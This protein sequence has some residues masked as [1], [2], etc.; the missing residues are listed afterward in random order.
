MAIPHSK[1]VVAPVVPPTASSASEVMQSLQNQIRGLETSRRR[2]DVDTVST[3]CSGLDSL[4]P[5]GGLVRG[6]IIEWLADGPGS[7]AAALSLI[8]ARNACRQPATLVIL[9]RQHTFYP[10]AAAAWGIDLQHTIVL[11]PKNLADQNWALQ[12]ALACPAVAAVWGAV[13][14]ID[15]LAYRRFQL[16]AEESGCL[17]LF[18]RPSKVR[19]QPSWSEIQLAVRPQRSD[20]QQTL[21]RQRRLQ[22][23][24]LRCRGGTSG[25]IIDLEINEINGAL[26]EVF[27]R[28]ETHTRHLAAQLA[29]PKTGRR[30]AGA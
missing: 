3:G 10:P 7:S 6:T 9:D 27:K 14:E 30:A 20:P 26:R 5:D 19:G 12:Q 21:Y 15:E 25:H 2:T 22:I 4:L 28:H 8:A 1:T 29:H 17:G 13:D 18:Y 11:R 24:L 23:K 16:A